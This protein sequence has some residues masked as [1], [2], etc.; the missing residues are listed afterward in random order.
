MIV[1]PF[2][3]LNAAFSG[4][5]ILLASGETFQAALMVAHSALNTDDD[6]L[7]SALSV[8]YSNQHLFAPLTASYVISDG[9]AGVYGMDGMVELVH[10]V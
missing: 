5:T 6:A 4:Q 1:S 9:E 3:L 8:E 2:L 7:I 10:W